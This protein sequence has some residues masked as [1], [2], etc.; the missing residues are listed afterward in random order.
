M[1]HGKNKQKA[2]RNSQNEL[3]AK[4]KYT[5]RGVGS[6][7]RGSV[8][9]GEVVDEPWGM[10]RCDIYIYNKLFKIKKCFNQSDLRKCIKTD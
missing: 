2:K 4:L 5:T 8:Q 9:G 1:G 6:G 3:T 7:R 10:Q